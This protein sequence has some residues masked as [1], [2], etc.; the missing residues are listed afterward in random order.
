MFALELN[1]V[2]VVRILLGETWFCTLWTTGSK[3]IS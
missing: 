2:M 1:G 3:M